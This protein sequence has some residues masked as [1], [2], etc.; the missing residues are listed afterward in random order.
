MDAARRV[1]KL[2]FFDGHFII[3]KLTRVLRSSIVLVYL[4]RFVATF[5]ISK[6]CRAGLIVSESLIQ[7]NHLTL[8]I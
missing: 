5:S 7:I 3:F 2:I 8:G 1:N 4:R 6:I